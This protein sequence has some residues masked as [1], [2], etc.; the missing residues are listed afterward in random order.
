[1]KNFE[2]GGGWR[3]GRVGGPHTQ[4]QLKAGRIPTQKEIHSQ[5]SADSQVGNVSAKVQQERKDGKPST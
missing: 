5:I 1:M 2:S 4:K 3:V